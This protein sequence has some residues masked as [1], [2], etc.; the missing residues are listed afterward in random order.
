[1]FIRCGTCEF[2]IF[3][4]K[5][6]GGRRYLRTD[7]GTY[8]ENNEQVFFGSVLSVKPVVRNILNRYEAVFSELFNLD[9]A[10]SLNSKWRECD[11]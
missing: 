9:K 11:A 10:N 5:N 3:P 1:M 7:E 8:K 6:Y 2:N 4:E